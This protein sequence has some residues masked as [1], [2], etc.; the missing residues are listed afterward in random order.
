MRLDYDDIH[1]FKL[2]FKRVGEIVVGDEHVDIFGVRKRVGLDFADLRAIQHHIKEFRL[3]ADYAQKLRFHL[4]A[5]RKPV[6]G[7]ERSRGYDRQLKI[8][9]GEIQR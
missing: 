8:R 4:R 2:I 3:F 7:C 1:R 6:F 5:A 9:I